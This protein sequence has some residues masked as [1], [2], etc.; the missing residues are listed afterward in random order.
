MTGCVC[1]RLAPF[2]PL[3]LA[4]PLG[5]LP[6]VASATW[7]SKADAFETPGSQMG[8]VGVWESVT[9]PGSATKGSRAILDEDHLESQF[10]SVLSKKFCSHTSARVTVTT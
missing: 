8:S 9:V 3:G 2:Q 5:Q 1:P 6:R 4:F 7:P 10:P